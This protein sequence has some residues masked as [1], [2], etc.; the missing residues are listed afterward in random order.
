MKEADYPVLDLIRQRWSPVVFSEDP[1]EPEKLHILFE[2]AR[3]APSCYNEQPWSFILGI[4]D[5]HEKVLSC[6]VAANQEWAQNAPVLG[7]SIARLRFEK[8]QKDN[9]HAFHD[10]GLAMGLLCLQAVDIGLV[11]HQMAGFD[12]EKAKEV[13]QIPEGH[14]P[15][16]AFAIG[17][18]GD[19]S[20]AP[21]KQRRR[22]ETPS[23]RRS[24]SF[25]L[26]EGRW[27]CVA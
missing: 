23:G 12:P 11:V 20:K 26:F 21:E 9:R 6:L 3:W 17:Y 22:D 7:I 1:V 16:A 27:G 18:I 13:L 8:N 2:A 19:P 10:V 4:G 14:E 24:Q 15:V 25:F 5:T